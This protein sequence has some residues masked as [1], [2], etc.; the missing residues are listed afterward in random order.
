MLDYLFIHGTVV[1]INAR[2]EIIADG[3]IGVRGDRIEAVGP[4]E[5]VLATYGGA[6]KVID[7][8]GKAIFPGL[9]NTHNHLFQSLLKGLGDDRVLKDWLAYMTF[10]SAA[11]L[12]PEDTYYGAILGCLDGLH[13]GTTTMVDFMYPH[14]CPGLSDGILTA[15]RELGVRAVYGRGMMNT[16]ERHGVPRAIM[17]DVTTVEADCHRLFKEFHQADNGRIQIW[18][19]PAA[20]WSNTRE[21]LLKV[22]ELAKIYDT[23]IMVHISE[24]PFDRE[25]SCVEHGLPDIDV[26]EQLG[27]LGPKTLM[28]HCVYLTDRDVR[29]SKFFDARVSYNPV[30]NMYLSSGV[31]PIPKLLGWGVTV[32][33]A[34]DGAASNNSND[35]LETLKFAALLLKVAHLDPT[36]ITAEKV[37]EMATIDAARALGLEDRIGSLEVGKKADLFIFNPARTAKATPMHNP[38]ST[39]V[40][41]ASPEN[42]E[43][44]MI[45]GRVVLEDGRVTTVNEATKI[46]EANERAYKLAERA[47][48]LRF[49]AERPWRSLAY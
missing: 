21:M 47:G 41:S 45:D 32:G 46:K 1:T 23:G 9:I 40:Y 28:V 5:E 3:A 49:A 8:Q 38:V 27:M 13:S 19:A 30:S 4:T 29:L 18:L 22:K 43:L 20:V 42:I 10:P 31:A 7:A 6:R 48:T 24:T 44:V 14:C 11:F 15:F 16:G 2:R 36:V 35:M 25:A 34:T 26:L 37:L 39:L 12:T 33:L 17:Q